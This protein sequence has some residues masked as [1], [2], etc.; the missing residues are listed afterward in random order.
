MINRIKYFSA[1]LVIIALV[2][3]CSSN[4][5]KEKQTTQNQQKVEKDTVKINKDQYRIAEM[6]TGSK[7]QIIDLIA[8]TVTFEITH[9]G[10]GPFKCV[11]SY[12][13]GKVLEVLADVT[14]DYKGKKKMLIPETRAYILDVHTEGQWSVYRE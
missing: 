6:F 12:P 7:N 10:A 11:L 4:K 1:L 5:D 13:D 2:F 8:D 14:G 3:A 9:Q